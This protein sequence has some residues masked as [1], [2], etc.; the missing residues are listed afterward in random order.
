MKRAISDYLTFCREFRKAAYT[1]GALAPSGRRLASALAEPVRNHSERD[2]NGATRIL[3]VGPGTGAVTRELV[4]HVRP[5]DCLDLVEINSRFLD[6]LQ[7]RFESEPAFQ[8]VADRTRIFNRPIQEWKP[9]EDYQ[10]IICGL[11]F[12]NFEIGLVKSIFRRFGDLMA[13]HG[14]LVFFEYA[15]V[16]NLRL[17]MAT[18]EERRRVGG[19]GRVL[20]RYL[21]CYEFRCRTIY[22]NVPP[23]IV[24]YLR[25]NETGKM[26]PRVA[27]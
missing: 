17:L 2:Y 11:P 23:A 7:H 26:T 13:P 1:T 16:R 18:I 19:V 6:V 15:W 25:F 12:N 9:A 8:Q 10:F 22:A 4:R 5:G 3:E 27:R 21:N 20:R 14:T 24:H